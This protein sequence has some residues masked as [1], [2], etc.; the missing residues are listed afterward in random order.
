MMK[1]S[2]YLL[3]AAMLAP[4]T[5]SA[6]TTHDVTVGNNFFSPANL[7]IQVGDTVRW[8][9]PEDGGPPHNVVGDDFASETD[10]SFVFSHTFTEAGIENYLCTVHPATM[11]GVIN[12]QGSSGGQFDLSLDDISVNN[13]ITYQA[14]GSIA[15][16][17][18]VENL[19]TTN[20]TAYS[21][22]YYVSTD[23]NITPG[24]MFLGSSNRPA[25]EAEE[26][27]DFTVN[28]TLPGSLASGNYFIGGI[29]DIDDA[30]NGNNTNFEDEAI[31]VQGSGGGG[32]ADLS[33]TEISV[34]NNITYDAGDPIAVE[35]EI[36]N[37]GGATSS[38]F[39]VDY[40]VSDNALISETD[41]FLGSRNRAA[42]GQGNSDNFTANLTLPGNLATGNY[43]IGGIIDI[44]DAN[45]G[46]NSNLEDEPINVQ[47]GSG[48][49]SMLNPGHA[50][51]W[52]FGAARNGEGVQIEVSDNG[53]GGRVLVATMYSYNPQG[54]PIFLLAVGQVVD[55]EA[56]VDVFIF[57]GPT[58]GPGFDPDD[59]VETQWGSGFFSSSSCD[60]VSMLLTPNATFVAMGY[61]EIDEDLIRLTLTAIPCP[62]P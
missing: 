32:E 55:G 62:L 50:G 27:I 17:T 13:D 54:E 40:Y 16:D 11:T 24:D 38:A 42:L 6:Q 45:N 57:E 9:N 19:S 33:L 23:A 47:G 49:N 5:V 59:L 20:S 1:A 34:N 8:T 52:W 18:D 22:D 31:V 36:I 56:D 37:D 3:A 46:N 29:L 7:T 61:S 39:T 48:G 51:N 15:I 30:N 10:E 53:S 58:W 26:D 41:T 12:V 44:D 28:M 43:F 21:V 60:S 14:G 2:K 4:I 25:L 35:T